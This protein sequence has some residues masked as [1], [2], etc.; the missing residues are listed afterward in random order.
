MATSAMISVLVLA[1]IVAYCQAQTDRY[2]DMYRGPVV[3][4]SEIS[5]YMIKLKEFLD[6]ECTKLP[7][8]CP[9]RV[10]R[11]RKWYSRVAKQIDKVCQELQIDK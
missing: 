10:I 8:G 2:A 9:W 5:G 11:A 4:C 1:V 7:D 6:E 3:A